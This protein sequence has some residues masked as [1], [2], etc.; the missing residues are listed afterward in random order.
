MIAS[1]LLD[2]S[3]AGA[4]PAGMSPYIYGMHD[5]PG[6]GSLFDDGTGCARGWITTLRYI[7]SEG[8]CGAGDID[9][10]DWSNRGFGVIMRLDHNGAPALPPDPQR[11]DGYA[12]AFADC[13]RRAS[14]VR[15]WI[16]G[17]EPNLPWGHP[18][19]RPFTP[20]EYGEIY[21]RVLQ[22][23]DT[24]GLS[25]HEV[26][27]APMGPWASLPPWGDWDDGL[28]AAIDHARANG[29]RIDGV[30]IHAYSRSFSP[31]SITSDAWFP[32]RENKWHLHFRS[33]RDTLALLEDRGILN[34]PLY[35]T[36]AGSI[37]DA[38]CEPYP[39]DQNIGYFQAMYEEIAAWNSSHPD[40]I[41]RAVTPYRWTPNDDGSGRDFCIGCRPG[42]VADLS[43]A[44]ATGRRWDPTDCF[45][46][47]RDAGR[48]DASPSVDAA[49]PDAPSGDAGRRPPPTDATASGP[50]ARTT[51]ED[52]GT[53]DPDAGIVVRGRGPVEGSCGCTSA[54]SAD[55][56][57]LPGLFAL[58]GLLGLLARRGPASR[59]HRAS[60][61]VAHLRSSARPRSGPGQGPR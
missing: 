40:Q 52:T 23:V 30:A 59:A 21:R 35:I 36:E 6:D 2:A 22:A 24:A 15:V 54:R 39:D 49:A 57:R 4:V 20:A 55:A 45:E 27:F 25:E 50:D 10:D 51:G 29:G 31:S 33:Y 11:W 46:P 3:P 8:R 26:L 43:S 13:V 60:V 58:F 1:I 12:A 47:F 44:A 9:F 41:V 17:N 14:G 37:C 42:L 5:E 61:T 38:P 28:G 53:P 18:E 16:V 32:G 19:G 48:P 7:G 34:I 56:G